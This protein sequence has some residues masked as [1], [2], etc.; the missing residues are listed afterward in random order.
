MLRRIKPWAKN[1]SD[2]VLN[3]S[4]KNIVANFI[5]ISWKPFV[6]ENIDFALRLP[7]ISAVVRALCAF[8]WVCNM[9]NRSKGM[10]GV[11]SA[12]GFISA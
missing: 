6:A 3:S 10:G 8:S 7:F 2:V 9:H 11:T 12:G 4:N 5:Q 1:T